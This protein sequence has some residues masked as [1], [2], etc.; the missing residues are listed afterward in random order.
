MER[1]ASSASR[2][3]LEA[4][5]LYIQNITSL[6]IATAT[7]PKT[8][9]IQQREAFFVVYNIAYKL[10]LEYLHP[11]KVLMLNRLVLPALIFGFYF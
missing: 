2:A 3:E 5:G 11:A 6:L 9:Q 7:Y 4:S 8:I 10:P 1:V